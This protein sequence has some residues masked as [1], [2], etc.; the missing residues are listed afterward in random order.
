MTQA[1]AIFLFIVISL[2][3]AL[4]GL[5]Y[6]LRRD[7]IWL[8]TSRDIDPPI[9]EKGLKAFIEH[10]WDK[11]LGWV[12]K[13][14]TRHDEKGRGDTLTSYSISP[15]GARTNPGFEDQPLEVLAIGD[16]FT[17]GRQVN[18]DETWPH[19]LSE[20]LNV[21]VGNYG[22]GNYGL[23]QALLRLERD[24][25]KCPASVILMGVVPETICRILSVWKHFSEYGNTFG[26]K[27]RFTLEDGSLKILTNPIDDK[28]KFFQISK[29]MD[30]LTIDDYFF[31]NKFSKDIL[32]FPFLWTVAR[33]WKRTIP[34]LFF[35]FTDRLRLTTDHTFARVMQRNISVASDLY[36]NPEAISLFKSICE[37]FTQF[38]KSRGAEP[39]LVMI[40]QMMDLNHIRK[41]DH[42]YK[43]MLDELSAEMTVIDAAPAILANSNGDTLYTHDRYGGHLSAEG[44]RILASLLEPVCREFMGGRNDELGKSRVKG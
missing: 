21:N 22:V 32:S 41:G 15:D 4:A 40:P 8:I 20:A 28:R 43:S 33:S 5:V 9:D 42:F 6:W 30:R 36:H 10:G 18:D 35:A 34:L 2:E 27:P 7:C 24:F 3:F 37:R 44:N 12:R 1:V 31:E 11:T 14:D 19:Q 16:S 29:F 13:P 38:A 23:D 26:F 25:E 39:V 17:F